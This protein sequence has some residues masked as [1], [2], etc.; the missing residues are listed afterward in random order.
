MDVERKA[1][2]WIKGKPEEFSQTGVEK[3]RWQV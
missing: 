3:Q 1:S 2:W